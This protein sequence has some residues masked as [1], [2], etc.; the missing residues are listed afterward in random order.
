MKN[1]KYALLLLCLSFFVC[2]EEDLQNQQL[3]IDSITKE[4]IADARVR[5][6]KVESNGIWAPSTEE[7]LEII[8]TDEQGK[9]AFDYPI[10]YPDELYRIYVSADTYFNITSGQTYPRKKLVELD[11]EGYLKVHIVRRDTTGVITCSFSGYQYHE[12]SGN[13]ID[14][15]IT[16]AYRANLL[17]RYRFWVSPQNDYYDGQDSI[18][19][20]RHDTIFQ[21][22]VF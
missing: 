19:I 7:L 16:D 13:K 5:L 10:N 9:Y 1:I 15:I 2:C 12:F 22:I 3:V 18:Y 4:P 21:E 20:P 8:Y 17:G 11:P 14:T 6:F